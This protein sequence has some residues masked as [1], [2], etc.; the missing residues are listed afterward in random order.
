MIID[1]GVSI[2]EGEQS[3]YEVVNGVLRSLLKNIIC[4]QIQMCM[5][6]IYFV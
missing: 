4:P 5:S 2:N 3:N 6:T 1:F